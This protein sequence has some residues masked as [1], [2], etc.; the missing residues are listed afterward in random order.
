MGCGACCFVFRIPLGPAEAIAIA[1]AFGDSAIEFRSGEPYIK[2]VNGRCIFLTSDGLCL[3]QRYGLKPVAC[4]IWPFHPYREPRH[5]NA[6]FAKYTYLGV[7]WYVY[8]DPRCPGVVPGNPSD[9]LVEDV[10]PEVIEIRAGLRREQV[11]STSDLK[12]RA[13]Q[14]LIVARRP[15]SEEIFSIQLEGSVPWKARVI[16]AALSSSHSASLST[17]TKDVSGLATSAMPVTLSTTR[18]AVSLLRHSGR[19][20]TRWMLWSS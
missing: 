1:R 2:R 15:K 18:A 3:L 11:S 16:G 20:N 17:I 4:K 6:E 8:V 5:G 10:I 12:L 9:R 7:D 19:L 13:C 14:G